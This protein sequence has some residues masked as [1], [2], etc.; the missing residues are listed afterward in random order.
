MNDKRLQQEFDEYFKGAELPANLT[1]DAKAEVKPR[2]KT[3]ALKWFLRL[4]PVAAMLVA[5]ICVA[6]AFF[7][8]LS[9]GGT[10]DNQTPQGG[11]YSYYSL[12]GLAESCAD[13]YSPQTDGL[14]FAKSLAVAH[15]ADVSLTAYSENGKIKIAR[16]DINLIHGAYRHDAVIYVEYT[17]ENTCF[18][19]LK[20]YLNGEERSYSGQKYILNTGYDNGENIYKIYL[21]AGQVKYYVSVTTSEIRGYT[22]YLDLLAK[23]F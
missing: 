2:K 12:A 11:G 4:A 6:V 16:A 8:S 20:E 13:P 19:D 3:G 1:A 9:S 7:P 18:E 17:D 15:N 21:N 5:V 23:Y 10:P 22:Y 14:E